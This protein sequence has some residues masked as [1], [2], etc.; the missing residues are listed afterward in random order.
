MGFERI[1]EDGD[2]LLLGLRLQVDEEVPADDQVE[3]GEGGVR[4][5]VLFGED[6]VLADLL[7]D[8]DGKPIL[9]RREEL[10]HVIRRHI[11]GDARGVGPLPCP[12][13]GLV[14]HVGGE[15]LDFSLSA[16]QV[17][18]VVEEHGD[19]VSLLSGGAGGG[20]DP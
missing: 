7:A 5:E 11:G 3:V 6:Y 14:V 2:A 12:L 16:C 10:G 17:E 13:Q 1:V 15:D 18:L 19:G 8:R 4:E 20:P 9:R